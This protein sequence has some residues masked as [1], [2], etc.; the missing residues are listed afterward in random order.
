MFNVLATLKYIFLVVKI[1]GNKMIKTIR[2]KKIKTTRFL[3][4]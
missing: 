4:N 2:E 1:L 3:F